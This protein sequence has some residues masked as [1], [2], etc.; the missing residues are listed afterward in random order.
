MVAIDNVQLKNMGVLQKINKIVI[1]LSWT[2]VLLWLVRVPE[3][4]NVIRRFRFFIIIK[5]VIKIKN[6]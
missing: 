3:T 4:V 1:I 2:G 6:M 5:K